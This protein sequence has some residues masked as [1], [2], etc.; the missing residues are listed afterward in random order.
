MGYALPN[1]SIM[2]FAVPSAPPV[3]FTAVG[4]AADI[5]FTTT[6]AQFKVDDV[7]LVR[8]DF[9]NIDALV[10][11][12]NI[13]DGNTVVCTGVRGDSVPVATG[14]TLTKLADSDFIPLPNITG[15]A[16][17]GGEQQTITIQPE[18]HHRISV[19]RLH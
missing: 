9:A 10:L 6:G 8:A 15:V 16:N 12:V 18:N 17:T 19:V 7:V 14:G 5:R 3:A 1:G 4:G 13:V 2:S 11:K